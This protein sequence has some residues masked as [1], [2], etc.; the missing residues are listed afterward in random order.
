MYLQKNNIGD[1]VSN[2]IQ[3]SAVIKQTEVNYLISRNGNF[4]SK[5]SHL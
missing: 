2:R 3:D 5:Y 1:E 4:Q